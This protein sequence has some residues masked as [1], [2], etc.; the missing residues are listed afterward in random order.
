MKWCTKY[1]GK[2]S[3]I[4]GKL[5]VTPSEKVFCDS[6]QRFCCQEKP[7]LG[8][9]LPPLFTVHSTTHPV[10]NHTKHQVNSDVLV[11][12]QFFLKFSELMKISHLF[13]SK[14]RNCGLSFVMPLKWANCLLPT[15]R[16]QK[17]CFL[18]TCFQIKL[19]DWLK[20]NS[21]LL[22]G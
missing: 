13:L 22:F 11:L 2:D 14:L 15:S 10:V 21:D 17:L 16:P 6:D 3:V 1:S 12:L 8:T 19:K 7:F 20:A 9:A 18:N 4:P 5:E